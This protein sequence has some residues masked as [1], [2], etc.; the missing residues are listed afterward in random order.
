MRFKIYIKSLMGYL[1]MLLLFVFIHFFVDANLGSALMWSL[2][3][4]IVCSIAGFVISIYT[5]RIACSTN[6]IKAMKGETVEFKVKLVSKLALPLCIVQIVQKPQTYVAALSDK[7]YLTMISSLKP[8]IN[9]FKYKMTVLGTDKIGL[10]AVYI[11]DF[12][13]MFRYSKKIHNNEI[14]V[15][16]VPLFVEHFYDRSITSFQNCAADYDDSEEINGS[17]SSAGG[18]PGYEYREYVEGDSLK[19]I[20]YKLSAKRDKLFIRLDEPISSLRQA[21]V[22]DNSTS[23]DRYKDER[24]IEGMIAYVGCM[25]MENICT[26]VYFMA[27]NRQVHMQLSSMKDVMEFVDA[28]GDAT[29]EHTSKYSSKYTSGIAMKRLDRLS[30]ITLFSSSAYADGMLINTK[31]P[32]KIITCNREMTGENV[33][34]I[35]KYLNIKEGGAGYGKN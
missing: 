21:V 1:G 20:N 19:R 11:R 35:D 27:N 14:K 10:E 16:T 9:S 33:Y 17:L 31:M 25:V 7:Y 28:I 34:Y 23:G 22:L 29:F 12:M 30:A 13:G 3:V 5:V 2:I 18:F 15:V 4:L 26:E 32:Y 8:Y 6:E 24:M